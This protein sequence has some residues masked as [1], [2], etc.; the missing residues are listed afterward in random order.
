[1]FDT[2]NRQ[3][4]IRIEGKAITNSG[5]NSKGTRIGFADDLRNI[6]IWE[7][8]ESIPLVSL[9]SD[10]DP[11]ARR[12]AEFVPGNENVLAYPVST[13]VQFW[14]H[15]TQ[16]LIHQLDCGQTSKVMFRGNG[17]TLYTAG[18]QGINCWKFDIEDGQFGPVISCSHV[19]NITKESVET[20]DI[21]N[22][23]ATIATPYRRRSIKLI[24]VASGETQSFGNH[25]NVSKVAFSPDEKFLVTTTWQGRGI[26][27]WDLRTRKRLTTLA[28]MTSTSM[29]GF[30]PDG[31]R[32][33]GISG[34]KNFAWS[35]KD[36][37]V[38]G[39]ET[40][41]VTDGWPGDVMVSP[42]GRL[43]VRTRSQYLPELIDSKT[44]QRLASLE[45]PF[46]CMIGAIS[47]SESGRYVSITD[48]ETILV[49]DLQQIRSHLERLKIDWS[50]SD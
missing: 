46:K 6:G 39:A 49:W 11:G 43:V 1:M 3:E 22:A 31:K 16:T 33:L 20:F 32:M 28:P 37:N 27:V 8:P 29:I 45:S 19:R 40:R 12:K 7:L 50:D 18:K 5:F 48:R 17:S 30:H 47:W 15:K 41:K 13:G 10:P 14:N 24:D 23:E 25:L 35:T 36:W 4:L 34:D 38:Q 42:D 21:D 44:G 26:N 2:G 9:S